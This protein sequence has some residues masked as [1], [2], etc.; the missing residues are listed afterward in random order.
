MSTNYN[1]ITKEWREQGVDLR[2]EGD[3][4]LELRKDGQV[5]ARFSQTGVEISNVLKEVQAGKYDN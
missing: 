4:I 2:E 1:L 3:H 5:I